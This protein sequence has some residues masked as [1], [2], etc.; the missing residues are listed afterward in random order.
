MK[1][2][3]H[4]TPFIGPAYKGYLRPLRQRNENGEIDPGGVIAHRLQLDQAPEGY[5]MFKTEQD[6]CIKGVMRP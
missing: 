4:A 1:V 5:D 2:E 6:D 3:A